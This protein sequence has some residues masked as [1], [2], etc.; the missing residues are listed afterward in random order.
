MTEDVQEYGESSANDARIKNCYKK[1]GKTEFF[2]LVFLNVM[3]VIKLNYQRGTVF[4]HNT[5]CFYSVMPK[6]DS[7]AFL[8][9]Y[10]SGIGIFSAILEAV[11]IRFT[12]SVKYSVL[13][14]LVCFFKL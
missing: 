14:A 3:L 13:Y 5:P 4:L 1:R 6:C 10:F 9:F 8:F 7:T 11:Y 12:H 2:N